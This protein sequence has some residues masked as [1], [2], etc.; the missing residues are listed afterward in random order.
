M[1]KSKHRGEI[2]S[3]WLWEDQQLKRKERRNNKIIFESLVELGF[4]GSYR[5]VCNYIA[6]WRDRKNSD[7]NHDTTYERLI[8][9]PAEAQLDFGL[10][11][12]VQDGKYIDIH[13]LIMTLPYSNAG[14]A[15]PLPSE[16]QECFL[17]GLERIFYQVGGV[18]RTIRIDNLK[19]AV[20]K[21][22]SKTEETQFTD[23]FL[24]FANFY[25]FTP[26]ACNPYSGHEKGNVENKVGYVRYNFITPAPV[27]TSLEHFEDLLREELLKDLDRPHHN[28]GSSLR[29]LFKEECKYLMALPSDEKYS[30]FKEELAKTNKYGEIIV[31][32]VKIHVPKGYNYGQVNVIKYW[33]R[34]KVISPHGE[35][36]HEDYRPYM[37]KKRNIPW[38]SILKNWLFKPRSITHSRYSVYLLGRIHEYLKIDDLITRKE[39]IKWLLSLIVTYEIEEIN[40]R[41]YELVDRS[42][43]ENEIDTLHPYGVDWSKYDQLHTSLG[44]DRL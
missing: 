26:Q 23:E 7:D 43:S 40:E 3:D 21:P 42:C 28:K 30:V 14:F 4:P 38:N 18:P 20:I 6:D 9:P 31:D 22:R 44:G 13:C 33:N 17:H 8:H 34:F 24:Q 1:T 37:H 11:S 27:I 36:L 19:A 25:G 35:I 10:M 2:V 32:K 41:F 16:N 29:E 15:I 5:T 39:R 12:A